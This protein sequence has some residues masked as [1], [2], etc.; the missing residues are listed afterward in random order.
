MTSPCI[1]FLSSSA[2][3][4]EERSTKEEALSLHLMSLRLLTD[5]SRVASS[6]LM[7]SHRWTALSSLFLS[8]G[9]LE[10]SI[11]A[12]TTSLL[13]DAFESPLNPQ[14]EKHLMLNLFGYICGRSKGL[15]DLS[16][17][18]RLDIPD[19]SNRR[20]SLIAQLLNTF[21]QIDRSSNTIG[22]GKTAALTST[23]ILE[24][25]GMANN[26]EAT[27]VSAFL[28]RTCNV[29]FRLSSILRVVL[30]RNTFPIERSMERNLSSTAKVKLLIDIIVG[31]G[32][33]LVEEENLSDDAFQE[34][35]SCHRV[36]TRLAINLVEA[37]EVEGNPESSLPVLVTGIYCV[38]AASILPAEYMHSA[39][40]FKSEASDEQDST[41]RGRQDALVRSA[42]ALIKS[43]RTGLASCTSGDW[44]YIA[45]AMT[46]V[47]LDV[48][49]RFATL[50]FNPSSETSG[51]IQQ[52]ME[53]LVNCNSGDISEARLVATH[54]LVSFLSNHG[55]SLQTNGERFAAL[56]L[57]EWIRR[58]AALLDRSDSQWFEASFLKSLSPRTIISGRCSFDALSSSEQRQSLAARELQAYKV[59]CN[60]LCSPLVSSI[61]E[62]RSF[63][64]AGMSESD[65]AFPTVPKEM[66]AL[67]YW[68][69]GTLAQILAEAFMSEGRIQDAMIMCKKCLRLC[70]QSFAAASRRLSSF[71]RPRTSTQFQFSM[72]KR[73]QDRQAE[74]LMRLSSLYSTVGDYRRA[75]SYTA[76]ALKESRLNEVEY[77]LVSKPG[78]TDTLKAVYSLVQETPR[79]REFRRYV[80][81][82]LAMRSSAEE[83]RN[84]LFFLP[85]AIASN[86]V[87]HI[88]KADS[89]LDAMLEGLSRVHLCAFAADSTGRIR[90]AQE[91]RD[92]L[93]I[94]QSNPRLLEF[95][96]EISGRISPGTESELDLS[97]V[98]E[99][100]ARDE[101]CDLRQEMASLRSCDRVSKS[102]YA[103]TI[104]KS[105]ALYLKGVIHLRTARENGDLARLWH[106]QSNLEG[107][108]LQFETHDDSSIQDAKSCFRQALSCRGPASELLS[109]NIIRCLA[110]VSGPD[111]G[112]DE[113]SSWEMVHSSVGSS[114]R[115]RVW[116]ALFKEQDDSDSHEPAPLEETVQ[117]V[118]QSFDEPF[119]S[120]E[121]NA[122][123]QTLWTSLERL[124]PSQWRVVAIVLCPTGEL[125]LNSIENDERLTSRT[126]CV[127]P[128]HPSMVY[129]TM[130][131]PLD[132]L[133]FKSQDQLQDEG[134][135][136]SGEEDDETRKRE[137][138]SRR[139]KIDSGLEQLA[140]NVDN[141]FFRSQ[142]ARTILRG[143]AGGSEEDNRVNDWEGAS[144]IPASFAG[145]SP[146]KHLRDPS[147]MLVVDLREALIE[148]G[149]SIRD[150]RNMR[151]TELV[152]L[153][154]AER[155]RRHSKPKTPVSRQHK[156]VETND[157]TILV[158]DEDL[159]RFPFEALCC[160]RDKIVC[161][162]P[163]LSFATA[164]L[165]E[166]SPPGPCEMKVEPRSA[167]YILDPES[168]LQG[169]RGRIEEFL[170]SKMSDL[171][172]EWEGIVGMTPT[173][174]FFQRNLSR[175]ESLLLFFGHGGGQAYFSRSAIEGMI[176]P[177]NR[178]VRAS[179]VLM[180]CSSGSLVSVNRK[181]TTRPCKV[182]LHY[183]PEGIALSYIAAGA[184]CVIGNLWDVTDRDIDRLAMDLL[185]SFWATD[186][187]RSL[188]ACLAAARSSCK[189]KFINGYAP[190]YY[191]LPVF[192]KAP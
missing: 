8:T 22:D 14:T 191:G 92:R 64:E 9:K 146:L 4:R 34:A 173:E 86:S 68:V 143:E 89:D 123:V 176:D 111:R 11:L 73:L 1:Q 153:L 16:Q 23:A 90:V 69:K 135:G 181:K 167:S 186:N 54:L 120:N 139:E 180:G 61:E 21:Q 65:Q 18:R 100:L 5:I 155:G 115:Q 159:H 150:L 51:S 26:D 32:T 47:L 60:L 171:G 88:S 81:E 28:N 164:K 41:D 165:L 102:I 138:W 162:S 151:K 114:S 126:V 85:E 168:N 174:E 190:V 98:R 55:D 35:L 170:Q 78:M 166:T 108:R 2:R 119:F 117:Q 57:L 48:T 13:Y 161:R 116:R 112:V 80:L 39:F 141:N 163:S 33:H 93:A 144:S 79:S 184:P 76:S 66:L 175:E 187:R 132:E 10:A 104:Q 75:G 157:A 36:I 113:M 109:R 70:K 58:I 110:L 128:S 103:S 192:P 121:R 19:L 152:D 82:S 56:Q 136:Q 147:K 63:L 189:M 124:L 133:I 182:P 129:D 158:L 183:E 106:G 40:E 140:I 94:L 25:L 15:F 59:R 20:I 156:N 125:L 3:Q 130:M 96:K 95:S 49:D 52:T 30:P 27:S 118:L 177:G 87:G 169:T 74:V 134:S 122:K 178:K 43:A 127:F 7:L 145:E 31:L 67:A 99:T 38:A 12:S 44:R 179:V 17:Y 24:C 37:V 29:S 160:L 46:P 149:M 84:A 71:S 148:M 42:H 50:S 107:T 105:E 62:L 97:E 6:D 188:A 53:R 72:M 83:V 137:W 142:C 131:Q 77:S 91:T 154:M 101:E 185:S 45:E 172:C